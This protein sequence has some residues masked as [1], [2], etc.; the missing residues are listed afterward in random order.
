MMHSGLTVR[1]YFAAKALGGH[2]ASFASDGE[3]AEFAS[4]IAADCASWQT[5]CSW[6]ARRLRHNRGR[7]D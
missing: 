5:P 7:T 6:P 4:T 1:D 3:P 2:L